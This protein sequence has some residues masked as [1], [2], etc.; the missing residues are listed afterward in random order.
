MI[1]TIRRSLDRGFGNYLCAECHKFGAFRNSSS[2][3]PVI[4]RFWWRGVRAITLISPLLENLQLAAPY[5]PSSR[6]FARSTES[7]IATE[8]QRILADGV[9]HD[10]LRLHPVARSV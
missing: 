2:L 1:L 9:A 10:V 5:R 7:Q 4:Y 6:A 3:R 8:S